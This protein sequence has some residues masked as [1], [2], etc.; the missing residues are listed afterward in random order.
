M[1][2]R[3]LLRI[4]LS[5][6]VA[7]THK[8]AAIGGCSQLDEGEI[9]G[10]ELVISGRD[11]SALLDLIEEPLD[12][13]V[14]PVEIGAKADRVLAITLWWDVRQCASFGDKCPDQSASYPRS[15]KKVEQVEIAGAAFVLAAGELA[16]ASRALA[17]A[18]EACAKK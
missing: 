1:R 8:R 14:V 16:Q 18:L 13:I 7:W 12:Q 6:L 15:A 3:K 17:E 4:M 10:G 11:A 5:R 2:H 9:V